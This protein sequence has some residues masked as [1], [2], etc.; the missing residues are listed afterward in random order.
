VTIE[1]C[2]AISNFT[3]TPFASSAFISWFTPLPATVQV[4]YG[5]TTN[6]GNITSLSAVTTNPVVLLTGL[7]RD[8]TYYF[9]A[10]S[11]ENGTLYTTNGS[12]ATVDTLILNTVNAFYAGSWSAGSPSVQGF[13]GS[14]YNEANTTQGNANATAV[15]SPSIVTPGSYNVFTWYP[16]NGTFSTN[17]QMAV[18]G[19]SNV[20]VEGVNQTTNGGSWQPLATNLYFAAGTGGNVT[21]Y[22]DTGEASRM[23]VAN[24][25]KWSYVPGQDSAAG[26]IPGWWSNWWST[27][28]GTNVKIGPSNYTEYVLGLAPTNPPASS[29]FWATF[30]TASNVVHTYFQPFQGGRIYQMQSAT[31]L[32]NPHWVALTNQPAVV[33]IPTNLYTNGTGYGMFTV[34]KTNTAPTYYRLS[35]QLGTNY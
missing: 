11:W 16:Q 22:N 18:S 21:I 10:S 3:V 33:T 34:T 30:V 26:V 32:T 27:Y 35:T 28:L 24:A 17:T 13:Y 12:F 9:T 6:Y 5:L 1:P 19:L 15:Y 23:V 8:A 14:Y 25:M 31:N 7:T 2:N 29:N 20:V 4:A